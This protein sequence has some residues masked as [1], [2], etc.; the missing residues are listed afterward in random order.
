MRTWLKA[1]RKEKGL[2]QKEVAMAVDIAQSSYAGIELGKRN[3]RV[4]TAKK[5]A[6]LLGFDWTCF[7]DEA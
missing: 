7:F 5:I 3:P 1:I 4:E 6:E 2:S